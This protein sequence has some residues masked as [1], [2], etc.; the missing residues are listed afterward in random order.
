MV[1]LQTRNL[2]LKSYCHTL[3]RE[4]MR[5]EI[6]TLALTPKELWEKIKKFIK[7]EKIA[8]WKIV[9]GSKG[10][11]FL[12]HSTS[13]DQWF[14]KALLK[15]SILTEPSRLVLTVTWY[16]NRDEPDEYTKGL[17]VGR[18]TEQLLEHFKSDFTKLVTF[19]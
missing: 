10:T 16:G 3:Q 9:I 15:H 11:E 2:K 7:E 12:T 5:I 19:P 1:V 14:E 8:T 17:Y 18:F 4:K 6:H 13:S